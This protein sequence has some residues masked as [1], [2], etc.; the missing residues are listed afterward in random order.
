[1]LGARAVLAA[2]RWWRR[3]WLRGTSGAF[4]ALWTRVSPRPEAGFNVAR[5]AYIDLDWT[6]LEAVK[7]YLVVRGWSIRELA[8]GS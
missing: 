3:A 4:G 7:W 8:R 6:L 2:T 1:V 5:E